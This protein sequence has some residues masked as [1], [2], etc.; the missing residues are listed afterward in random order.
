M[1]VI[2]LTGEPFPNGM[3]ATNR[4]MC[5]ARAIKEGGIQ[6]EVVIFRRTERDGSKPKNTIGQGLFKG[7][8]FRYISGTP[9]RGSNILIR[10]LNDY[11]DQ[12]RT[13][14]FLRRVLMK[15]D[16]LFF[17]MGGYVKLMLRYM[18]TAHVNEAFCV[19][20]LCEFPFGTG[21][22]TK[23]AV[24]LRKVTI[25]RQ[26][27]RLDGIISI[28]DA[29]LNL[30]KTNALPTCKHIKVPIMVE[31][32]H[33]YISQKESEAE[34]PYIFHAG[35]LSQQ[36][37]GILGMIEAFGKAK[38]RLQMPIKYVLTGTIDTS[39]QSKE[40]RRLINKY[41][42]DDSVQFVGYLVREQIKEYLSKASLVIS[43]RPK[44]KQ[45]YYGF[46]TKVGEY[47][48]S[49]TPLIT[50]NWGEAVN[51]LKDG[52]SAYIIEPEDIN[53]L[54]DAIVQ[55][56]SNPIQARQ[57]GKAGQQLCQRSFDYRVW[58][59]PLVDFMK[60]LGDLKE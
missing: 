16:V 8:P 37:D 9:L 6:C 49:G 60:H 11:I 30:A 50:T 34:V 56:F 31:Y 44:S 43:N 41:Q 53:A 33:Y 55:V 51:W 29:L 46:S 13:D 54:A 28:S 18:R 32:E 39:P 7:I 52:E 59:K 23:T 42:L 40:I 17:F 20:D 3:A 24:R 26:F 19:R 5:Y 2:I 48:A 15:G 4:I 36:K 58:S 27:P 22:E 10:R 47:L 21:A 45:D 1:K 12:W 35:T 57:I 38:Q 25:E 14:R